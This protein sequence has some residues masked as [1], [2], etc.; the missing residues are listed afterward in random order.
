MS[1]F[2]KEIADILWLSLCEVLARNNS[3]KSQLILA[4]GFG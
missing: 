1:D 4:A 2:S 3:L